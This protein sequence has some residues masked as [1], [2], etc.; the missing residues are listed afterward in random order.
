MET[1]NTPCEGEEEEDPFLEH[2]KM[3]AELGLTHDRAPA[4]GVT[5]LSGSATAATAPT[6]FSSFNATAVGSGNPPDNCMAI[7]NTGY[8]VTAVNRTVA[9]YNSTGSLLS[10]S[11]LY[12]FMNGP[13]SGVVDDFY[14]PNILFDSQSNRFFM[15]CCVG[16]NSTN[17]RIAIGFSSSNNPTAAWYFYYL[18]GNV[19]NNSTWLDFPRIAYSTNEVYVAGNLFTNSNSFNQAILF[20]IPKAAGYA[21]GY[22]NYQYWYNIAGSPSTLCPVS[23]GGN[24]SYGPGVYLVSHPSGSG[25]QTKFYNLTNDMSASNEALNYSSISV[26]SYSIG[27]NVAQSGTTE[28]L[29]VGDA[30]IQNGVYMNGIIHYVYCSQANG[31]QNGIHYDRLTVSNNTIVNKRIYATGGEAFAYPAVAWVGSSSTDKSVLISFQF[32]KSSTFPG[33]GALNVDNSNNLSSWTTC[34][35]GTGY[36]DQANSN[37]SAV[38]RWGDYTGIC[39][40]SNSSPLRVWGAASFG[41]TSHTYTCKVFQF[42]I[43]GVSDEPEDRELTY[44]NDFH[45]AMS[46]FPNP[47]SNNAVNLAIDQVKACDFKVRFVSMD[48]AFIKTALHTAA[49]EGFN[50]H[51]IDVSNVPSGTYFLQALND[52]KL[53]GSE[54][55]VVIH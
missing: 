24:G 45:G 51:Q 21:G 9:I 10:S 19:L 30:R 55:I 37:N 42:G 33:V 41:N 23:Y 16:R 1:L 14:D 46:V 53:I 3:Q 48:G 11:S 44:N 26:S 54:K 29:D 22:L 36:V 12:N 28:K 15:V 27:A 2:I 5:M 17:S 47:A 25:S 39:R 49:T 52:D 4:T 50:Q 43:N 6:V 34:A 38:S 31:T 18:P 13:G 40:R 8:I 35:S 7:S 32:S 20:Q